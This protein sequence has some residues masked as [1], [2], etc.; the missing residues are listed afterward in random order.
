MGKSD[1][2]L[3]LAGKTLINIEGGVGDDE[4]VFTTA[5]GEIYKLYHDQNCCEIVKI[6]D[7]CGDLS[8]LIGNP[9][10]VVEEVASDE[11]PPG[12]SPDDQDSFTWTFYKLST[13]HGSVTIRWYGESNGH[14]SESVD[15]AEVKER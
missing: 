5:E 10:L 3:A 12:V 9:L 1:F 11:N 4:M 15:F 7:I 13:I 6:E 14:Y 2:E 8:D